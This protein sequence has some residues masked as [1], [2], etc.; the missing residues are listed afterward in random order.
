MTDL[1]GPGALRVRVGLK[2][3]TDAGEWHFDFSEHSISL[4]LFVLDFAIF[5]RVLSKIYGGVQ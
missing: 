4:P 1:T 3:V 5:S 2:M